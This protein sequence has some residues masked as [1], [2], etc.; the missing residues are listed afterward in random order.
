MSGR[1]IRL[2]IRDGALQKLGGSLTTAGRRLSQVNNIGNII[3]TGYGGF[4][5]A[6]YRGFPVFPT[7]CFTV[8]MFDPFALVQ[9]IS[10]STSF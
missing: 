1:R 8:G 6:L 3:D 2:V 4:P 9:C 10:F 5:N 7:S